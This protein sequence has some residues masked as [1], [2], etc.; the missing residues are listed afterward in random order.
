MFKFV[1]FCI[2]LAVVSAA[3][4]F[5]HG[6]GIALPAATSYSSRVDVHSHSVPVITK[7]YV[8]APVEYHAPVISS[9]DHGYGLEYDG[10]HGLGYSGLGYGGISHGYTSGISHGHY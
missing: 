3:P 2:S 4:G 5:L 10:V 6:H 8:S 1:V 7:S 9:I